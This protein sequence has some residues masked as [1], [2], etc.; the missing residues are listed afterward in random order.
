[1]WHAHRYRDVV[2]TADSALE[3]SGYEVLVAAQ[4]GERSTA[5]FFDLPERRLLVAVLVDAVRLLLGSD[6]RERAAVIRWVKAEGEGARVPFRD[7][8]YN[9][10]L[11]PDQT[12]RKLLRPDV[13]RRE[14]QRMASRR[15][16]RCAGR[17]PRHQ[18]AAPEERR[19]LSA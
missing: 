12:A 10:D 7:L 11:D 16:V 9:L 19:L 14:A 13:L 8:C 6:P 2:R 4:W 1:M 15:R 18:G 5:H 17:R 3:D